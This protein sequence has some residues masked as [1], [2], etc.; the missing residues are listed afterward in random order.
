MIELY[1]PLG[2][3]FIDLDRFSQ[4]LENLFGN[5]YEKKHLKDFYMRKINKLIRNEL[6]DESEKKEFL[7]KTLIKN[8]LNKEIEIANILNQ[9]SYNDFFKSYLITKRVF[10]KIYNCSLDELKK[11]YLTSPEMK[12]ILSEI[13]SELPLINQRI[14]NIDLGLLIKADGTEVT[15]KEYSE[16]NQEPY[17]TNL[18]LLESTKKLI[19]IK[20]KRRKDNSFHGRVF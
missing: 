12:K 18:E 9:D 2:V 5:V 6:L 7:L 14:Y 10:E 1:K 16:L 17:S 19:D 11:E 13:T 4:D 8:N 20:I 15:L 3:D